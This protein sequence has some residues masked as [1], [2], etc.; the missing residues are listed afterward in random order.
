MQPL[1]VNTANSKVSL[2]QARDLRYLSLRKTSNLR[3]ILNVVVF[4]IFHTEFCDP[5][6]KEEFRA[7]TF[8]KCFIFKTKQSCVAVQERSYGA[9][10]LR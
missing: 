9:S 3:N 7:T 8:E 4:T 6:R 10:L 5:V 1:A 2:V